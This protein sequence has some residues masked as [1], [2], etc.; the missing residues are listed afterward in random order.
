MHL[1]HQKWPGFLAEAMLDKSLGKQGFE[2]QG[3]RLDG[4]LPNDLTDVTGTICEAC[5]AVDLWPI[6]IVLLISMCMRK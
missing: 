6:D 3:V 1:H 5:L 2:V 4:L